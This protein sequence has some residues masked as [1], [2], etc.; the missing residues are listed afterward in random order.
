MRLFF[1]GLAMKRLILFGLL[2]TLSASCTTSP[3][4]KPKQQ[5]IKTSPYRADVHKTILRR[6]QATQTTAL[7][8]HQINGVQTTQPPQD[9]QTPIESMSM[10]KS[11]VG[12]AVG[13]L[14]DEGKLKLE[15]PV[16]TW[17]PQWSKAPYDTITVEHLLTHRSGIE[18]Y[19]N[20]RPIYQSKDFVAL[21][22]S[23]PVHH[24]PGTR[25][26]YNN[27]ALNL[28]AAVVAKASGQSVSKVLKRRLFEPLNITR[29]H[30]RTDPAGNE[31]GM[32]G[33]MG[34]ASDWAK[35][36]MVL[37]NEG[38]HD[39]KQL[40]SRAWVKRTFEGRALWWKVYQTDGVK[41]D[42]A[43]YQKAGVTPAQLKQLAP[44]K[45][46][47][48]E[49]FAQALGA[50]NRALGKDTAM[51]KN[52]YAT[53]RKS[54]QRW[55]QAI[56]PRQVGIAARGYLGQK[57]VILPKARLVGVRMFA[58]KRAQWKDIEKLMPTITF[59]DFEPLMV[60][61]ADTNTKKNSP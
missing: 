35:I 32:A 56:N 40:I 49:S 39:D 22:L 50:I 51:R 34:K 13:F 48:F 25:F 6:A 16:S 20:T 29:W 15:Q 45:D 19:R 1:Y 4:P 5:A 17:F 58:P 61:L 38:Q 47:T 54:G 7:V 36:A 21:A 52:F 24:Q 27:N 12:L 8:L 14:V 18:P 28:L 53:M 11:L 26:A 10:T 9:Q 55:V 43:S 46:K 3:P 31:Q 59:Q 41:L 23:S 42:M 30:W 33:F 60:K 44:L 37:A 2:I 57:T